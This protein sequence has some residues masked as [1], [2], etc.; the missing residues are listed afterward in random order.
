M[1]TFKRNPKRELPFGIFV[2]YVKNVVDENFAGRLEVW[3]PEFQTR[4]DD[5][6]GWI[7]CSYCSPFAGATNWQKNTQ[8][9][10]DQLTS[11]EGT[12][13]SYGMWMI[14]PDINNEVLVVFPAGDMSR[15]VWLGGMFKQYMN[16]EVPGIPTSDATPQFKGQNVPA[17]E[18]N[19]FDK[20]KF[21]KHITKH[22]LK[23]LVH[24]D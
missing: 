20:E 15:A 14:P 7:L 10:E 13:T 19:K 4:E 5:P 3:I 17:A 8:G 11:F 21:T 6:A 22:D 16:F 1:S 23:E 2:G 9:S 24:K 18:Y 12:Q